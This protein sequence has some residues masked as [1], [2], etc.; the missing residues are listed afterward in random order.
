MRK[1]AP[2]PV[3]AAVT[4]LG[5]K[6]RILI[7]RDLLEG[8]KRFN[9]LKRSIGGISHKVLTENLRILEE[10]ALLIRTV[11]YETPLKVEYSLTETGAS[12]KPMILFMKEWG[13]E[14]LS[15]MNIEEWHYID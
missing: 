13:K 2:C 5:N 15:K 1:I 11:Y 14:Y 4:L 6:W 9:E 10:N 12:L 7:I 3:E 8:T